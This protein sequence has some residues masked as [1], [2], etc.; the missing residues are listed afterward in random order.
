MCSAN[1]SDVALKLHMV[2][3]KMSVN[4][5]KRKPEAKELCRGLE[6]FSI[7]AYCVQCCPYYW[8]LTLYRLTLSTG[9]RSSSSFH[10]KDATNPGKLFT[11]YYA[12]NQSC[13]FEFPR[14]PIVGE[15]KQQQEG[16]PLQRQFNRKYRYKIKNS[17]WGNTPKQ[18]DS[19]GI[20]AFSLRKV[21]FLTNVLTVL[22]FSCRGPPVSSSVLSFSSC[23][24]FPVMSWS[25]TGCIMRS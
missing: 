17:V 12:H 11:A 4:I 9:S 2:V 8:W 24:Y 21:C 19:P 5:L 15:I 16:N 3:S 25:I 7:A 13:L 6:R 22:V 14:L 18:G 23:P 20:T 1:V 10:E